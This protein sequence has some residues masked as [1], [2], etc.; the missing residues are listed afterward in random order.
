MKN[1]N[2]YSFNKIKDNKKDE[3]KRTL[4]NELNMINNTNFF[5]MKDNKQL[6]KLKKDF[7]IKKNNQNNNI[8]KIHIYNINNKVSIEN[9]YK[10]CSNV[11]LHNSKKIKQRSYK[12][13]IND[14][15]SESHNIC[16]TDDNREKYHLPI[17]KGNH[18]L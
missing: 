12:K 5:N 8:N 14:K 4:Q 17:I 7:E 1:Y 6:I 16:F 2:N 18:I 10:Y 13:D 9:Q 3:I 15:N 11:I